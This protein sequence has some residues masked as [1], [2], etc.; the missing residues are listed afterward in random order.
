MD[1]IINIFYESL[2][3]QGKKGRTPITYRRKIQIFFQYLIDVHDTS[4]NNV[5]FVLQSL[6][7]KDIIDSVAY[8]VEKGNIKYQATV[9]GYIS[10]L[11]V[12]YDFISKKNGC[13]NLNFNDGV[14][15]RKL[16]EEYNKKLKEL[17][18]AEKDPAQPLTED[19]YIRLLKLCNEKIDEPSIQELTKEGYNST[20]SNFI[21]AIIIKLVMFAGTKNNIII[22]LTTED[23]IKELNKIVIN[24]F[25]IHLPDLYAI[26]MQKY[27]KVRQALLRDDEK[28]LS[29][30]INLNANNRSLDN[31][32]MFR[33]MQEI[34]GTSKAVSIAKYSVLQMIEQGLSS[35]L[36]MEFTGYSGDVFGHCK[37]IMKEIQGENS[38]D[39]RTRIIDSTLRSIKA[40]DGL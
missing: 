8:Y 17:K 21:S 13:T 32:K 20:Y 29:L 27:W 28:I 1:D 40:Y 19:E 2:I 31:A 37:E 26:Q 5:F 6:E 36:I 25:A 39:E 35:D 34:T 18:L 4:E 9:D 11:T 12:F 16:K 3:N 7:V 24:G 14:E 38:K 30:F 22:D 23:Y 15:N 33:L 10:A